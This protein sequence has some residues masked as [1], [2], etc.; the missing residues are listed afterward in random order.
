[1]DFCIVRPASPTP[2]VPRSPGSP[3]FHSPPAWPLFALGLRFFP[4]SPR[5][6]LRVQSAVTRGQVLL[7][8]A[9]ASFL[10]PLLRMDRLMISLFFSP[11]P[12]H[13]VPASA[14][15][16]PRWTEKMKPPSPPDSRPPQVLLLHQRGPR[17]P[18]FRS[19]GGD[20]VPEPFLISLDVVTRRGF[21]SDLDRAPLPRVVP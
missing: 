16:V 15:P 19:S 3:L 4:P 18:L 17:L 11:W 6:G 7:A 12:G 10:S 5:P 8:H 13:H 20:L 21:Q 9:P 2:L 14:Q 1:V